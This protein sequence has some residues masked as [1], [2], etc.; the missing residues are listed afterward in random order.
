MVPQ[1]SPKNLQVSPVPDNIYDM[2]HF[3]YDSAT[4][5]YQ[6]DF[7]VV[8]A[9]V[10]LYG[11]PVVMHECPNLYKFQAAHPSAVLCPLS[12]VPSAI[13][14]QGRRLLS[15]AS[16]LALRL[17]ISLLQSMIFLFPWPL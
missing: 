11:H 2:D 9:F 7:G 16:N 10:S 1:A 15:E 8:L 5:V 14:A 6:G 3:F 13:S 4:K 17:S 12:E